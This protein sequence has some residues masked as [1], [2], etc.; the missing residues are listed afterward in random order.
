[1]SFRIVK[2]EASRNRVELVDEPNWV[3]G[4]G[5]LTGGISPELDEGVALIVAFSIW[6][7]PDRERAYEAVEIAKGHGLNV[8]IGLL[9]Y[10][11]PEELSSWLPNTDWEESAITVNDSGCESVHIAIGQREGNSPLWFT[12]R[13]GSPKLVGRGAVSDRDIHAFLLKVQA[14]TTNDVAEGE[15]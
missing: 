5:S 2:D 3:I 11:Y 7:T 14:A 9:P 6:S 12:L 13:D 1:M 15:G 4:M 8:R 10:D